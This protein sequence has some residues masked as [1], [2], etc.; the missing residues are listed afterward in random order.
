MIGGLTPQDG[1]S[2]T[3]FPDA[4]IVIKSDSDDF[5]IENCTVF[6]NPGDGI[7]VQDSKR[8]LIFNNLVYG[9][10]GAGVAIVGTIKGSL[11]ARIL[12]NTIAN[13]GNRGITI[14]NTRRASSRA[15]VKNN[16]VQNNGGDANIKVFSDPPSTDN[17]DGDYDLVFPATYIPQT[18]EGRHDV[19][20]AARFVGGDGS[21]RLLPRDHE[22]GHQQGHG[23]EPAGPAGQH[24][25]RA[26]DQLPHARQR[27]PRH[28]IPFPALSRVLDS[29]GVSA[30]VFRKKI[31][32]AAA[33]G[34]PRGRGA[35]APGIDGAWGPQARAPNGGVTE[36]RPVIGGAGTGAG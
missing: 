31:P 4:G 36:S 24:P 21:S 23:A 28:R 8:A 20:A 19:N 18:I 17:Y 27:R 32:G 15:E 30:R 9:N 26:V 5:T 13:N 12:S 10:G 14:G 6:D 22:P 29:G 1:F 3:G 16:I 34:P 35:G 11:E 7:R 2:I 33:A 25:A